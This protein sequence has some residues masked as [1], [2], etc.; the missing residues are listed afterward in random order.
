M[1]TNTEFYDQLN[2]AVIGWQAAVKRACDR[3]PT[4]HPQNLTAETICR[5]T[6][7][8]PLYPFTVPEGYVALP[9]TRR[10]VFVDGVWRELYD[11]ITQEQYDAEQA[12]KEAQ[13]IQQLAQAFAPEL[14]LLQGYLNAI[15]LSIPATEREVRDRIAELVANENMS[16]DSPIIGN[17]FATWAQIKE[18][19]RYAQA[20][21]DDDVIP[22][23][24][25]T[26]HPELK[27]ESK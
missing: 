17:V 3:Q 24:W 16:P 21:V 19:L 26:L 13:R 5:L 27:T 2:A 11:T 4:S 15:G 20:S 22:D 14:I 1:H 25:Y 23:M 10:A 6:G 8:L 9:G 18:S 7:L 12:A